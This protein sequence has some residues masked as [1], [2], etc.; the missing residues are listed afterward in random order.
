MMS[1]KMFSGKDYPNYKPI[2][3]TGKTKVDGQ[4]KNISRRVFQRKDIDYNGIDPRTGMTN[5]QLM[6]KGRA[7]YWKDGTVIELHHLIQREPGSIVELP[8]SMHN[9]YH[10]ILHGLV[11]NGGSFR[12]DLV[13]RKQYNNF[14]SKY[15]RWRANQIENNL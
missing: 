2:N 4:I 15:W 3:Y 11:E 14:R 6:K 5:F 9:E 12:N 7:P 10:K 8:S 13:L 1:V